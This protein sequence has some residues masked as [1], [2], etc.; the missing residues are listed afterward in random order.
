MLNGEPCCRNDWT[1]PI[2]F[3]FQ[4]GILHSYIL[5]IKEDILA[6]SKVGGDKRKG[7]RE[8]HLS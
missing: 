7:V 4:R 5:E 3:S 6:A 8:S 1:C 2:F